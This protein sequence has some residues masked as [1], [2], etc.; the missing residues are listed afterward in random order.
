MALGQITAFHMPVIHL[1]IDV[2]G[3][4]T[5]RQMYGCRGFV[6]HHNTDIHGD[7]APQDI[8]YP[9]SYWTMGGAWLSTHLWMHY[10]YTL[11]REFLKRAF[12]VM[13]EAA[14]RPQ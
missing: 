2:D 5:V 7:A 9:G 13:A 10:Q 11:D 1:R 3:I 4:L 6:A 12:P 14:C 8:W